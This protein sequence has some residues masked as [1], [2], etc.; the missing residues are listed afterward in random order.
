M[1]IKPSLIFLSFFAAV[2]FCFEGAFA[3]PE[4]FGNSDSGDRLYPAKRIIHTVEKNES[5]WE[6]ARRFNVSFAE[7]AI[8]NRLA[9][10]NLIYPGDRLIIEIQEDLSLLVTAAPP[11]HELVDPG[12]WAPQAAP[13]VVVKVSYPSKEDVFAPENPLAEYKIKETLSR[14]KRHPAN[15]RVF[16]GF[17]EFVEWLSGLSGKSK[18]IKGAGSNNIDSSPF[19]PY[20]ISKGLG[21]KDPFDRGRTLFMADTFFDP[22]FPDSLS[23]P[24]KSL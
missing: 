12:K 19:S 17:L 23:P 11:G 24:P 8:H 14:P 22:Y 13:E 16:K 1:K 10:P 15:T 18:Q 21:L 7:M 9:N 4:P 6:I 5:L 20:M 2:F 3:N